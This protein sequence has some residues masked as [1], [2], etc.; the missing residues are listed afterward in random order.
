MDILDV[1][2][3]G[4][5]PAGST[6]AAIL[7]REGLNIKL[8]DKASFPRFK[9]CAGWITDGVLELLG[10]SATD[11]SINNTLQPITGFVIWDR[12]NRPHKI[13][14]GKR[15]SY[16]IVRTE[17]DKYLIDKNNLRVEE[18]LNVRNI[19]FTEDSVEIT[20]AETKATN[21]TNKTQTLKTRLV[22]GAGGHFCP[23]S[24][25]IGNPTSDTFTVGAIESEFKIDREFK[26]KFSLNPGIP[27]IFFT[28]EING[29]AWYI[30][31]GD[32]LNIGIGS[33]DKR[34]VRTMWGEF[35]ERLIK[36]KKLPR[37]IDYIL[38]QSKGH[39]YKF[40]P[41][42]P[43]KLIHD[44]A[45]LIGDS[46]GLAY[47]VSGEGIKPAIISAKIA[48]ETILSIISKSNGRIEDSN[49]TEDSL[50]AYDDKIVEIFGE[51]NYKS[52]REQNPRA[53]FFL[54]FVFNN[55]LLGTGYGRKY[56]I[57]NFFLRKSTISQ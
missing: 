31:K 41:A 6:I 51:R 32:Y 25:A 2:V 1:V 17:F 9:P 22:I 16:G 29:Y 5:G 37:D 39:F 28:E 45:L 24:K 36:L 47:N 42:A 54:K 38:S 30:V 49:F 23:V 3:V 8:I 12:K 13:D 11:Y 55:I 35:L 44:R 20:V 43:R 7:K 10:V 53:S 52:N 46:A 19:R 21:S 4:A 33:I 26:E 56:V 27:E 14:Y 57:D 18:R 15:V 50:K 40:Y 34:G 48:A